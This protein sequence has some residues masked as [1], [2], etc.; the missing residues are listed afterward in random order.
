MA[1]SDDNED[2]TPQVRDDAFVFNADR[3]SSSSTRTQPRALADTSEATKRSKK[4]GTLLARL[5]SRQ[6]KHADVRLRSETP[7][8]GV[9]QQLAKLYSLLKR[10]FRTCAEMDD[11]FKDSKLEK[12]VGEAKP[13]DA[14]IVLSQIHVLFKELLR[15]FASTPQRAMLNLHTI[16]RESTPNPE[17]VRIIEE[18]FKDAATIY[19][20]AFLEPNVYEDIK[21]NVLQRFVRDVDFSGWKVRNASLVSLRRL[22]VLIVNFLDGDHANEQFQVPEIDAPVTLRQLISRKDTFKLKSLLQLMS[23]T[24]D[25]MA[26][27]R[28]ASDRKDM[29]STALTE[30]HAF[31][32]RELLQDADYWNLQLELLPVDYYERTYKFM[33]LIVAMTEN[34]TSLR[35]SNALGML[36]KTFSSQLKPQTVDAL[37]TL[38]LSSD[39]QEDNVRAV[40][41][42][43]QAEMLRN[44]RTLQELQERIVSLEAQL[45]DAEAQFRH[46]SLIVDDFKRMGKMV[47][48]ALKANAKNFFPLLELAIQAIAQEQDKVRLWGMLTAATVVYAIGRSGGNVNLSGAVN[49]LRIFRTDLDKNISGAAVISKYRKISSSIEAIIQSERTDYDIRFLETFSGMVNA[50]AQDDIAAVS[51]SFFNYMSERLNINVDAANI[52]EELKRMPS[53]S[54]EDDWSN[55]FKSDSVDEEGIA[56]VIEHIKQ[57]VVYFT[58]VDAKKLKTYEES[59]NMLKQTQHSLD[60]LSAQLE[61]LSSQREEIQARMMELDRAR[62]L[63]QQELNRVVALRQQLEVQAATS[64]QQSGSVSDDVVEESD[65][66]R[67]QTAVLDDELTRLTEESS[68]VSSELQANRSKSTEVSRNMETA[69]RS[70]GSLE[71]RMT[72]TAEEINQALRELKVPDVA[73][74]RRMTSLTVQWFTSVKQT[75]A[76]FY[77]NQ[78]LTLKQQYEELLKSKDATQVQIDSR[79]SLATTQQETLT[80]LEQERDALIEEKKRA[81]AAVERIYAKLSSKQ[82]SLPEKFEDKLTALE[83]LVNDPQLL[84]SKRAAIVDAATSS[85]LLDA[86]WSQLS[87]RIGES[88]E[89]VDRLT[90]T[91]QVLTETNQALEPVVIGL[92]RDMN[93]LD[94][95]NYD[96]MREISKLKENV[97]A[98]EEQAQNL[99]AEI[100]AKTREI[101]ILREEHVQEL[102]SLRETNQ[103]EFQSNDTLIADLEAS[104]QTSKSSLSDYIFKFNS[105]SSVLEVNRLAAE[106]KKLVARNEA[107]NAEM[108]RGR[109]EDL[110]AQQNAVKAEIEKMTQRRRSLIESVEPAKSRILTAQQEVRDLEEKL[111]TARQAAQGVRALDDEIDSNISAAQRDISAQSEAVRKLRETLDETKKKLSVEQG[112]YNDL[113]KRV[114]ETAARS[115]RKERALRNAETALEEYRK[116]YERARQTMQE[117]RDTIDKLMKTQDRLKEIKRGIAGQLNVSEEDMSAM[118]RILESESPSEEKL[119]QL[120]AYVSAAPPTIDARFGGVSDDDEDIAETSSRMQTHTREAAAVAMDFDKN[121]SAFME[122]M[123][124]LYSQLMSATEAPRFT[125]FVPSKSAPRVQIT[126]AFDAEAPGA[127]LLSIDDSYSHFDSIMRTITEGGDAGSQLIVDPAVIDHFY[128]FASLVQGRVAS[129]RPFWLHRHEGMKALVAHA[130]EAATQTTL[131]RIPV[132]MLKEHELVRQT[133]YNFY[134]SRFSTETLARGNSYNAGVYDQDLITALND[135]LGGGFSLTPQPRQSFQY[136]GDMKSLLRSLTLDVYRRLEVEQEGMQVTRPSHLSVINYINGLFRRKLDAEVAARKQRTT[137]MSPGQRVFSILISM[138]DK[139]FFAAMQTAMQA[140][141][142]PLDFSDPRF[143]AA[144]RDSDMADYVAV[145]YNQAF[146]RSRHTITAKRTAQIDLQASAV[147]QILSTYVRDKLGGGAITFAAPRVTAPAA[148]PPLKFEDLFGSGG[149][150]TSDDIFTESASSVKVEA[151][152]SIKLEQGQA[153]KFEE[154]NFEDFEL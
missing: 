120:L 109:T 89:V 95:E 14:G 84:R 68:D 100:D 23:V 56:S 8:D 30:L 70:R 117:Q 127:R 49:Q 1:V 65:R 75:I 82:E 144:L 103:T 104:L 138:V 110:V 42:D 59:E 94:Q 31:I 67:T 105:N 145:F 139:T 21:T 76:D 92:Q 91:L 63:K 87:E 102:Q 36:I 27:Q 47:A 112:R 81:S 62:V 147:R 25:R 54:T 126:N 71:Q 107:L 78:Y 53:T 13:F 124:V 97:G 108:K 4:E 114:D 121:N 134:N 93:E 149:V 143:V 111:A 85:T 3:S 5:K 130:I 133:I 44:V 137:D 37:R 22:S 17:H 45:E 141:N 113:Q 72:L 26:L 19:S 48:D 142:I 125:R 153:V 32:V 119:S 146:A 131:T 135:R 154:E 55:S 60:V 51:A 20:P 88:K 150:K 64:I 98:L 57:E 43:V 122:K 79:K 90:E 80:R 11:V 128:V 118:T 86:E 38:L 66:I 101:E 136:T 10:A 7:S 77:F 12:T 18:V 50:G 46:A 140:A 40:I 83:T 96:K 28:N 132:S 115:R 129:S 15:R 6:K 99:Q 2:I 69:V 106:L 24:F 151:G 35:K 52:V 58:Q 33:E 123:Q 148:G 29:R 34:V 9:V 73:D 74:P 152:Q 61:T 16:L 39:A 41:A 116:K